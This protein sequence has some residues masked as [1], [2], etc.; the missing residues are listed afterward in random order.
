MNQ[1]NNRLAVI[2]GGASGIGQQ[3]AIQLSQYGANIA[4]CDLSPERMAETVDLCHPSSHV[5]THTVDVSNE[6]QMT[7]FATQVA[8]AHET[9]SINLLFNNAGIAGGGSFVTDETNVWERTFDV[10]WRGVYLGCRAFMPMLLAA[11]EAHIINTSSINGFW[12]S[13]GVDRPHTAY[14]AAKFAVKGFTEA[15]IA[16]LRTNAPHIGCSVVMPGH[17]GT[18]IVANSLTAHGAPATAEV[19][20][21]SNAFRNNAATTAESAAQIILDGVA[22]KRWRILV[23]D[24][25]HLLDSLVRDNPETA[26]EP[27]FIDQ[28]EQ[29]SILGGLL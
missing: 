22:N 28:L 20:E 15:L 11:D 4:L 19:T 8:S 25:A 12:A 18:S 27:E 23:G 24:D 10:C 21:M 7:S 5:S 17:I 13:I 9:D 2:T 1:F 14:S 29:H 6:S 16:D 26:Y 3:L